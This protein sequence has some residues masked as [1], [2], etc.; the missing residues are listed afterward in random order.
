[1]AFMEA[2]ALVGSSKLKS[3]A[4]AQKPRPSLPVARPDEGAVCSMC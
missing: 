1:M 2:V 3:L 4:I